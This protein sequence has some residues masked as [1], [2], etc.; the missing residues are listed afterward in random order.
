[1]FGS[2]VSSFWPYRGFSDGSPPPPD[3]LTQTL[4][5]SF[6]LCSLGEGGT[7]AKSGKEVF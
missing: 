5:E 4:M 7:P 6:P 3:G 1:M 2:S